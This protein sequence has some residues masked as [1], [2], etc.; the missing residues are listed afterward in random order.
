MSIGSAA[1]S[2][3]RPYE[4]IAIG[5]EHRAAVVVYPLGKRISPRRARQCR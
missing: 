4:G 3:Q 1:S 5:G 2:C